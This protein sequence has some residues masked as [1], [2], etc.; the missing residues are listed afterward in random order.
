MVMAVETMLRRTA[1][2]WPVAALLA[3]A[4]VLAG[5][6]YF[7]PR[8]QAPGPVMK[9]EGV[10]FRYY[11]PSASRVQLAGNWP[12]NNWGRGD[13]SAGQAI[14]RFAHSQEGESCGAPA[15]GA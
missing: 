2:L 9:T 12:E 14:D 11:A 4:A 15:K 3:V 6:S 1:I 7:A 13:G 10:V 8:G 5:C